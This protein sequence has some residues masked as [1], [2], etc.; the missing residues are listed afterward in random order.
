M[1]PPMESTQQVL[2][3]NLTIVLG[4]MMARFPIYSLY[5]SKSYT[6]YTIAVITKR[7][8]KVA[9]PQFNLTGVV[10]HSFNLKAFTPQD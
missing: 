5:Y 7:F 3:K 4:I 10:V 6:I 1:P 9:I 8:K 2:L